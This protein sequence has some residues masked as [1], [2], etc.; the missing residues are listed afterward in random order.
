[1]LRCSIWLTVV[2]LRVQGR[3]AYYIAVT[4]VLVN[5]VG[6]LI[7]YLI[8]VADIGLPLLSRYCIC[9]AMACCFMH[10]V[11]GWVGL[12]AHQLILSLVMRSV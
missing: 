10:P 9:C 5:I 6:A 1:M 4:C 11:V 2:L 12:V 7:G 3:K 8:I